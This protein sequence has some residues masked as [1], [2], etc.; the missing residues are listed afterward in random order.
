MVSQYGIYTSPESSRLPSSVCKDNAALPWLRSKHEETGSAGSVRCRQSCHI[1]ENF[2]WKTYSPAESYA[3]ASIVKLSSSVCHDVYP[4]R[5][6]S[7]SGVHYTGI[8]T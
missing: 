3:I 5:L 1:A 2:D 6:P 8:T 4:D 7:F